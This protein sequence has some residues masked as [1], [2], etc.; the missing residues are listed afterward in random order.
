MPA[1]TPS[2]SAAALCFS[3]RQRAPCPAGPTGS[4]GTLATASV[5]DEAVLRR[6]VLSTPAGIGTTGGI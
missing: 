4:T 2:A 3:I 6:G 5:A 1:Q